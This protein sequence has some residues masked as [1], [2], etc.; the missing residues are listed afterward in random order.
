MRVEIPLEF[1]AAMLKLAVESSYIFLSELNP[2]CISN[3]PPIELKVK[4]MRW[5][6]ATDSFAP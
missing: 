1:R 4:A 3:L 5:Q 6:E 2:S